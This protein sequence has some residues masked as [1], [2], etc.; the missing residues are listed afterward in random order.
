[1][2]QYLFLGRFTSKYATGLNQKMKPDMNN[3]SNRCFG[4]LTN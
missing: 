2:F 1:M 4:V 3:I